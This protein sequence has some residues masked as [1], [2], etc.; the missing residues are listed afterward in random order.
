ME[1]IES[2]QKLI[3]K[4]K[5]QT[6]KTAWISRRRCLQPSQILPQIRLNLQN[7]T[8]ESWNP[9]KNPDFLWSC[10]FPTEISQEIS[11]KTLMKKMLSHISLLSSVSSIPVYFGGK[12]SNLLKILFSSLT[13]EYRRGWIKHKFSFESSNNF[14]GSRTVTMTRNSFKSNF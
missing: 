12:L 7:P 14:I 9:S 1:L 5:P 4:A 10:P 11:S 3:G 8:F 13:A 6:N 2:K